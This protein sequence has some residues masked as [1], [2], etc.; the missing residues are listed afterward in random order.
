M[1]LLSHNLSHSLFVKDSRH[2]HKRNN[3]HH[4]E[5]PV[6]HCEV[7]EYIPNCLHVIV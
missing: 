5:Y 2:F 3:L 1:N 6:R 4:I 7:Q